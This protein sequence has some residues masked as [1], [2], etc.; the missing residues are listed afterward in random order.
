MHTFNDFHEWRE[1]ITVRCGL[2]LSHEYCTERIA[3]LKDEAVPS[4]RIFIKE[5]GDGYRQA[6]VSWF[7]QARQQAL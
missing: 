5:Y 1:A 3:A 2:A 4:T 7:E 6:V